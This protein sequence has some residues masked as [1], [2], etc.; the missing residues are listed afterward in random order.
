MC[1]CVCVCVCVRES[2]CECGVCVC[3]V[4]G[5]YHSPHRIALVKPVSL[6]L[7]QISV[8]FS[9]QLNKML[10]NEFPGVHKQHQTLLPLN[11]VIT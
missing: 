5:V 3:V 9:L 8:F 11:T 10:R 6:D 1:V 4:C 2:S 7:M